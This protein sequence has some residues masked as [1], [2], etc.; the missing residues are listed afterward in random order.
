MLLF[1]SEAALVQSS[2]GTIIIKVLL[3]AL[4]L[5]VGA[6]FLKGVR[7]TDFGR[8]LVAALVLALLNATIGA[9]MN[10]LALPL[11]IMTLGLFT[12]IVNALV[13]WMAAHFVKGFDVK[14]FLPALWLAILTA[15]FNTILYALFL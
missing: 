12:F 1:F 7:I 13:I 3:N 11:R 4:A 5:F 14:G 10:F 8:A 9:I 15:L 6:F 2:L